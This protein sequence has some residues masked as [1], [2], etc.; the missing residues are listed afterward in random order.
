MQGAVEKYTIDCELCR[1]G[2]ITI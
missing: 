2:N 1:L